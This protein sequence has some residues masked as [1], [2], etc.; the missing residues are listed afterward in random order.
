MTLKELRTQLGL[1]QKDMMSKGIAPS[2]FYRYET[3]E[4]KFENIKLENAIQFCELLGF[5][6]PEELLNIDQ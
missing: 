5:D 3:G 6:D 1:T 4:M 2:A